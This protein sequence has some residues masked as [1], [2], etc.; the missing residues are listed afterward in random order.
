MNSEKLK[1]NI[2]ISFF[3]FVLEFGWYPP[4]ILTL[5]RVELFTPIF[6]DDNNEK[7]LGIIFFSFTIVRFVLMFF[8]SR[9][10]LNK[11]EV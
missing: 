1:F 2:V 4:E 10:I 6:S 3:G 8:F 9:K 7:P 11:S 5:L